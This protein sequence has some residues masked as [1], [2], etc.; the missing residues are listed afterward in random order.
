MVRH[1]GD[2]GRSCPSWIPNVIPGARTNRGGFKYMGVV[3]WD[4]VI[5]AFV[6]DP[7]FFLCRS[8]SRHF[9]Y[10]ELFETSSREGLRGGCGRLSLG[11]LLS[12]GA[13]DVGPVV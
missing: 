4:W 1:F 7:R 6:R 13:G 9:I 5:S 11:M 10:G 12:R 8:F 3:D 2:H